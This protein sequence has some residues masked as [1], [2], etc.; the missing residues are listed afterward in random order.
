[1]HPRPP[2]RET[3]DWHHFLL[4]VRFEELPSAVRGLV[5][6]RDNAEPACS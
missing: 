1:M 3:M 4:T 5:E 2:R 6:R